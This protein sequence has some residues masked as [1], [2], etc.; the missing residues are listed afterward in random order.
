[1]SSKFGNLKISTNMNTHEKMWQDPKISRHAIH[2]DIEVK[3]EPGFVSFTNSISW[4][5]EQLRLGRVQTE[6]RGTQKIVTSPLLAIWEAQGCE[7]V[8]KTEF[9]HMVLTLLSLP[10]SELPQI[11]PFRNLYDIARM[12]YTP[13]KYFFI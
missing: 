10:K 5:K 8:G 4:G 1:M 12:A 2:H 9:F 3:M 11:G 7:W 6:T 13:P